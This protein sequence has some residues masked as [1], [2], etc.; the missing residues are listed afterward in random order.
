MKRSRDGES[1]MGGDRARGEWHKR[2]RRDDDAEDQSTARPAVRTLKTERETDPHRLAQRQKQIDYGKNTLGYD[3]YCAQV[4]RRERRRGEHPMTPDKT[5]KVSKKRFD[6]MIRVWRQ[7]LHK[8]DPEDLATRAAEM[9]STE[10]TMAPDAS[11][12]GGQDASVTAPE[13]AS[14]DPSRSE[15]HG[16]SIFDHFE[17]DDEL[18]P[19]HKDG[20]GVNDDDDDDDDDDLL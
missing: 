7:A 15:S 11:T 6:G 20:V 4:P 3:R 17:D 1:D 18:A 14:S 13:A 16:P 9:P 8:Y 2:P 5:L 19:P 12:S 10:S